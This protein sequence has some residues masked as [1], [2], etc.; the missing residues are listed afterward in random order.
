MDRTTRSVERFQ[1]MVSEAG[2]CILRGDMDISL[3]A[4]HSAGGAEGI[5]DGEISPDGGPHGNVYWGSFAASIG[6]VSLFN[7]ASASENDALGTLQKWSVHLRAPDARLTVWIG[8]CR[9]RL[10][11]HLT[12]ADEVGKRAVGKRLQVNRRQA[13]SACRCNRHSDQR[14][15]MSRSMLKS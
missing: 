13:M 6:A 5:D 8:L 2:L 7:F 12:L 10:P 14:P 3:I 11:G 15:G 1:Y 9:D 4:R